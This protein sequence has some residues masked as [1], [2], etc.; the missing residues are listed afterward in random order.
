[1]NMYNTMD[2]TNYSRLRRKLKIALKISG[3]ISTFMQFIL[4][5]TMNLYNLFVLKNKQKKFF[6]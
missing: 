4:H 1:M 3:I 6:F 2:K 5:F